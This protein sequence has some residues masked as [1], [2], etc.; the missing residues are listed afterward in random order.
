MKPPTSIVKRR[1]AKWGASSGAINTALLTPVP[2]S[3]GNAGTKLLCFTN[4]FPPD[5]NV[6]T[7][8]ILLS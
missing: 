4:I 5:P 2:F 3:T 8:L 6:S 7:Y 1:M